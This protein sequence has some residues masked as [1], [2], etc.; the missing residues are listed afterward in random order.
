MRDM[1]RNLAYDIT[2]LMKAPQDLKDKH[3]LDQGQW[4][5]TAKVASAGD[6][7]DSPPG[8]EVSTKPLSEAE[9]HMRAFTKEVSAWISECKAWNA[10][11]KLA[12]LRMY[13]LG[14]ELVIMPR[15]WS[16]LQQWTSVS[17]AV[18]AHP[19]GYRCK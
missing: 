1:F 13:K 19:K 14:T 5:V 17:H 4:W 3:A 2:A 11:S 8:P 10:E 16:E 6:F 15:G 7:G 18:S 9:S 12:R